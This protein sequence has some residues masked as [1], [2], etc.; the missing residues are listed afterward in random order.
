MSSTCIKI[1]LRTILFI[2]SHYLC[3][4]KYT[5]KYYYNIIIPVLVT[6]I[7]TRYTLCACKL[8]KVRNRLCHN[9][10]KRIIFR[11]GVWVCE[12]FKNSYRVGIEWF[13]YMIGQQY[14]WWRWWDR[15][16]FYMTMGTWVQIL[17]LHLPPKRC[18]LDYF[19]LKWI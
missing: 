13:D 11:W 17:L 5:T 8:V 14:E 3:L 16:Y 6:K 2:T 1:R 19:F 18:C 4:I 10:I 7:I 12:E 9:N 15:R